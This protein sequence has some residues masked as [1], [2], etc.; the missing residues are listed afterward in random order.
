MQSRP[1]ELNR[2]PSHY[3]RPQNAHPG[4][5]HACD[6]THAMPE[7]T[8]VAFRGYAGGK[9]PEFNRATLG[10]GWRL[11]FYGTIPGTRRP[12]VQVPG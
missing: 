10:F 9:Q 2:R 5:P 7:T 3:E 8:P 1:S 11:S 6:A 12:N 4:I